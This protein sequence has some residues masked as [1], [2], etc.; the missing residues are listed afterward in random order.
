VSGPAAVAYALVNRSTFSMGGTLIENI[1]NEANL[2]EKLG[3][4]G[5]RCPQRAQA[6]CGQA[7]PP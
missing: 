1:T 5:A 2:S 7:A 3:F 6:S 4:G